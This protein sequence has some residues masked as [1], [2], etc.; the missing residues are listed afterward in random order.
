MSFCAWLFLLS[1]MFLKTIHMLASISASFLF[2]AE[3]VPLCVCVCV[4][5]NLFIHSPV[6][7][8]FDCFQLLV[9][10]AAMNMHLL[11]LV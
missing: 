6:N 2:V 5:H 3:R 4:C 8:Y 11:V 9:N 10:N 7:G 1:I